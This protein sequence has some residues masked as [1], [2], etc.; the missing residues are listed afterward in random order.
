M[1]TIYLLSMVFLLSGCVSLKD[2][3]GKFLK[4]N[5]DYLAEQ[6][7][8]NFPPKFQIVEGKTR[9]DT[10]REILPGVEIPCPEV[11]DSVGTMIKNKVKCP[12]QQI[13]TVWKT[14]VDTLKV[15][16]TANIIRLQSEILQWQAK[17]KDLQKGMQWRNWTLG[18]LAIF[19]VL[20]FII[21]R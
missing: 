5:P 4:A 18:V 19:L 2:R 20:T 15:E 6:C 8:L 17:N 10:L 13:Q 16:N 12:D 3:A 14:R 9:V 21:K 7:A 11:K 1:R